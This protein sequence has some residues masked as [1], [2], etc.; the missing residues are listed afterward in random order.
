MQHVPSGLQTLN[1][2]FLGYTPIERPVV[3]PD[4]GY[5]RVDVAMRMG[6][7]RLQEVV[8]TAT[9][10]QRRLELANDITILDAD[11]IVRTQPIS[12]V[13][14][15]LEGRVPGLTVEHTSGAPGD[16]SRLRLRGSSSMLKNNDPIVI[17]D[18]VRAYA[19]QS[20]STSA[21]LASGRGVAGGNRA[22][23]H[24]VHSAPSPLDQIDPQAIQTVEVL[25][26]PSAAT[27]YGPDAANGV[28]VITMKKGRAG[29]RAGR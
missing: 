26:G 17:V 15:L 24:A 27:L 19:K 1:V 16:P 9:G 3:V 18:G 7:T 20:D 14:Q 11:S 2:R 23:R 5:V 13:T 29:P 12:S 21:N 6:M 28:I 10:Q 4:T 22:R 8:T 25:K